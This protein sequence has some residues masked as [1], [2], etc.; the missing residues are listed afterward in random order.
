MNGTGI[1]FSSSILDQKKKDHIFF[2]NGA[3]HSINISV[4]MTK[5]LQSN[6]ITKQKFLQRI[7]FNVQIMASQ[8]CGLNKK[9]FKLFVFLARWYENSTVSSG[10]KKTEE[11]CGQGEITQQDIFTMENPPPLRNDA[12]NYHRE[13]FFMEIPNYEEEID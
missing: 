8:I 6:W 10:P 12:E 3:S 11:Q 4:K 1:N 5:L 7:F 13:I 9:D 2:D